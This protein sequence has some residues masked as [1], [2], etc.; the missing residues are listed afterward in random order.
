MTTQSITY[1]IRWYSTT[2]FPKTFESLGIILKV[3]LNTVPLYKTLANN[4][5]TSDDILTNGKAIT[6][7]QNTDQISLY[8]FPAFNEVVVA[9]WTIV[10]VNTHGNAYTY[11]HVPSIYE[12]ITAVTAVA[13]KTAFSLTSSTCALANSVGAEEYNIQIEFLMFTLIYRIHDSTC[14]FKYTEVGSF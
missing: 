12:S 10:D 9:N 14:P 1:Y 11:D 2:R 6:M 13:K 3:T 5:I 7:A 4:Y 8:W